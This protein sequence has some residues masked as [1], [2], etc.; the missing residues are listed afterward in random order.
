MWLYNMIDIHVIISMCIHYICVLCI[1]YII[2]NVA[3]AYGY[4]TIKYYKHREREREMGNRV[5]TLALCSPSLEGKK[6]PLCRYALRTEIYAWAKSCSKLAQ[7]WLQMLQAPRVQEIFAPSL[8][9]NFTDLVKPQAYGNCWRQYRFSMRVQCHRAIVFFEFYSSDSSHS[10]DSDVTLQQACSPSPTDGLVGKKQLA[11]SCKAPIPC[12]AW[13]AHDAEAYEL[14]WQWAHSEPRSLWRILCWR[15]IWSSSDHVEI[16]LRPCWDHVEI[17]WACLISTC[18]HCVCP[19]FEPRG[20][21]GGL[22]SITCDFFLIG[23]CQIKRN[24]LNSAE[25]F[26]HILQPSTTISHYVASRCI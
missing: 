20:G 26:K 23:I 21:G 7:S 13:V 25:M 24:C 3:Y 22:T 12:R 2:N 8:L 18:A 1:Y 9:C 4:G 14:N 17:I 11:K 15:C 16:I 19:P 6:H 10:D 5:D